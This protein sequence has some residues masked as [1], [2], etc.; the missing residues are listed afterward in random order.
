MGA[1]MSLWGKRVSMPLRSSALISLSRAVIHVSKRSSAAFL[2]P[3]SDIPMRFSLTSVH[4]ADQFSLLFLSTFAP[5]ITTRVCA[6]L[7]L[8]VLPL[9]SKPK[10]RGLTIA[11]ARA[12]Q[13]ALWQTFST[14]KGRPGSDRGRPFR[15]YRLVET[16]TGGRCRQ[17]QISLRV[18][19]GQTKTSDLTASGQRALGP[20]IRGG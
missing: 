18:A 6:I 1:L 2:H 14:L 11:E 4:P 7:L 3:V 13:G 15:V 16:D 12:E 17:C 10:P 9:V 8:T 19:S 20:K 5:C